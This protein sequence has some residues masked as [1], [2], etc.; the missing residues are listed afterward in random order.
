MIVYLKGTLWVVVGALVILFIL[1]FCSVEIPFGV[2]RTK[3]PESTPET[4]E[5]LQHFEIDGQPLVPE[6]REK[7]FLYLLETE[8]CMPKVLTEE[9][10]LGNSDHCMCD[11]I[12]LS[13]KKKCTETSP[14]HIEFI[15]DPKTTWATGRNVLYEASK[16]KNHTYM[17]Y[18]FMD[19]DIVLKS[20]SDSSMNAWRFFE[21]FLLRVEPAVGIA[22]GSGNPRVPFVYKQREKLNCSLKEPVEYIPSARWE[23]CLNA[24]HRNAVHHVLPYSASFDKISWWVSVVYMEAKCEIVFPGQVVIHTDILAVNAQHRPYRRKA[25][26][27][28]DLA[29]IFN[30]VQAS[31]PKKYQNSSMLKE[32]K[33]NGVQHEAVSATYCLPPPAPHSPIVPFRLTR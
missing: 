7:K 26:D 28:K 27:A 14:K 29:S 10:A 33:K 32:M 1:Y 30:E 23:A 11:V 15:F 8:N 19:D 18:I 3:E 4:Y 24:F 25:A 21:R 12:V 20:K 9:E 13:F 22:D 5:I 2:T 31:L 17:Y 6:P 16:K